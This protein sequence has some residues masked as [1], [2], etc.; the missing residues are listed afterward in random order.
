M[1]NSALWSSDKV[2]FLESQTK[3]HHNWAMNKVVI[4]I[5]RLPIF[6]IPVSIYLNSGTTDMA[7]IIN[8]TD[9]KMWNKF[10]KYLE[11]ITTKYSHCEG[12]C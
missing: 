2:Y 5:F 7:N 12:I 9:F 11:L 8:Y 4:L 6:I 10:L 1:A 3:C